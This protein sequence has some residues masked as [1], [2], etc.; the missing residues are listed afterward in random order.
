MTEC[1]GTAVGV[2]SSLAVPDH[3]F[4]ASSYFDFAAL[5]HFARLDRIVN[6]G[7]ASASKDRDT[8]WLQIDLGDVNVICAITTQ[9][10]Y[11]ID[12]WTK[13]YKLSLSLTNNSWPIY[14][15]QGYEKVNFL[16]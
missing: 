10:R 11:G 5:P 1:S 9:G 6:G 12:E 15:E 16:K 2:Q 13:T 14:Y 3:R 7:W 8:S 4:T